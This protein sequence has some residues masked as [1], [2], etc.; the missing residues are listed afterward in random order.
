MNRN[1][2]LGIAA[3]VAAVAVVSVITKRTGMLDSLMRKIKDLAN[4]V[5]DKF[6]GMDPDVHGIIPQGEDHNVTMPH[7]N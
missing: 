6:A 2:I 5:E 3:G 1:L 7:H 4:T